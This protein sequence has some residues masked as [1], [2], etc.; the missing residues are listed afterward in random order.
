MVLQGDI[1]IL[2]LRTFLDAEKQSVFHPD[3]PMSVSHQITALQYAL[4][5]A[6]RRPIVVVDEPIMADGS[7]S[8]IPVVT[9]LTA[10][11]AVVAR[12]LGINDHQTAAPIYAQRTGT[13]IAPETVSNDTAP[14]HE[15]VIE[16][17]DVDLTR[18]PAL[19]QHVTDPGPY[20]FDNVFSIA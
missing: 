10:S 16:G 17:D 13:Q 7:T 5:K 6:G 11:R 9:N 18:L 4:E 8:D 1:I 20:F 15:I 3:G 12:S 2:D 19:T 14:V